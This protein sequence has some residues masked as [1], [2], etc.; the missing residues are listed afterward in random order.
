MNTTLYDI[1]NS[2]NQQQ[3]ILILPAPD[4]QAALTLNQQKVR[5][6]KDPSIE[7][8]YKKLKKKNSKQLT[9]SK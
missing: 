4:Q 7:D 1:K 9:I 2:V 3:T 5:E 8:L 6:S